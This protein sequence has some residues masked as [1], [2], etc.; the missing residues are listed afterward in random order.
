MNI[1]MVV[2]II[3]IKEINNSNLQDLPIYKIIIIIKLITALKK[4]INNI[5]KNNNNFLNSMLKI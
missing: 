5:M 4:K 3:H 1:I 2:I